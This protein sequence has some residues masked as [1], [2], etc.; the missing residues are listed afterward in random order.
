MAAR[1]LQTPLRCSVPIVSCRSLS[2]PEHLQ[3]VVDL[4]EGR[5]IKHSA[6]EL[7]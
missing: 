1:S 5:M 2:H 3:M 7:S 4:V 6:A